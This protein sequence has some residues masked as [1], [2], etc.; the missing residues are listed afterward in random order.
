MQ[1]QHSFDRP[2]RASPSIHLC[3]VT[4]IIQEGLTVV[5]NLKVQCWF[6]STKLCFNLQCMRQWHHFPF[7]LRPL[8][9]L[10]AF[11]MFRWIPPLQLPFASQPTMVF[12]VEPTRPKNYIQD[13]RHTGLGQQ[14]RTK[15][16]HLKLESSM[17]VICCFRTY[18]GDIFSLKLFRVFS[19]RS[20]ISPHVLLARHMFEKRS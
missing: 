1:V 5:M 8:T 13:C 15:N 11:P 2:L 14:F 4:K 18:L 9:V 7:M 16:G 19:L 12:H 6:A 3:H 17:R 20:K 10:T